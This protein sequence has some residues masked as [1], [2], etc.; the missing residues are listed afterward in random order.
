MKIKYSL[1][2]LT[3]LISAIFVFPLAGCTDQPAVT[4]QSPVVTIPSGNSTA[5]TTPVSSSTGTAPVTLNISAAASLTDAV[6][7]INILYISDNPDVTIVPNFASSGTLQQQIENGAPVDVFLSAAQTQMDNL[8]KKNLLL[9]DTRR[10]FVYNKV[11]LIVPSDSTLELSSFSDLALDKV[12]KVAVGDPKSVPAGTYTHQAFDQLGI[13]AQIQSKE[14]LASDVRQVL[15]YVE[16]GNVDAGIVYSTD[17]LIS[18]RVKVVASAPDDIN[19]RIVYPAAVIK[20]SKV[21]GA[22]QDYLDFL[23]SAR[24]KT[25]FEKYGFTPADN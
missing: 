8:Q 14:V 19:S 21:P 16:S 5:A 20:D 13:T 22:A 4:T 9:D 11:V 6:K 12:K 15:T 1:V 23:F 10:N 2:I 18:A 25:V 7:E 17:A 3:L 24:A